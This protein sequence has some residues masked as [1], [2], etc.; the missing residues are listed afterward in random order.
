VNLINQ[1]SNYDQHCLAFVT[2]A[3]KAGQVDLGTVGNN[4]GAAQYWAKNPEGFVEHPGNL[5]PP[6]GALV[7]WGPTPAPYDNPYGHVGIYRGNDTV[8]SSASWPESPTGTVVH[9][10]SFTGRNAASD[11]MAPFTPGFYPYLGWIAPTAIAQA[12]PNIPH[13]VEGTNSKPFSF[14]YHPRTWNVDPTPDEGYYYMFYDLVWLNWGQAT[15]AAT[16][17]INLCTQQITQCHRGTVTVR[18][19]HAELNYESYE[20]C[21]MTITRSSIKYAVGLVGNPDEEVGDPTC[22]MKTW[23]S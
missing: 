13:Y 19:N 20:Y 6:V 12:V 5:N 21:W 10:F 15:T 2:D 4:N 1:G 3:Y 16:G 14:L 18:L 7:F 9:E 23:P 8:I 22:F 17:M 11:G